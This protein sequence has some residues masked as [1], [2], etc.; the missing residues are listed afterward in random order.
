M[1]EVRI[2]AAKAP[3]R[4]V[5]YEEDDRVK[6]A[7]TARGGIAEVVL[8]PP[9]AAEGAA[10]SMDVGEELQQL[11]GVGSGGSWPELGRADLLEGLVQELHTQL[12]TVAKGGNL[13]ADTLRMSHDHVG[14]W[15]GLR[16]V[17]DA[18]GDTWL[19]ASSRVCR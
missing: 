10:A 7:R 4:V 15:F 11:C 5:L 16:C 3:L 17:H 14:A 1:D 13:D 19:V 18:M 9:D 6:V 12:P 8:G 2:F